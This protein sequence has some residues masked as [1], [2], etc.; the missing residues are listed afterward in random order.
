VFMQ[1]YGTVLMRDLRKEEDLPALNL[2]IAK[3]FF[4]FY[5]I[6]FWEISPQCSVLITSNSGSSFQINFFTSKVRTFCAVV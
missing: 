1:L 3:A 5:S 6:L 4:Y 2:H